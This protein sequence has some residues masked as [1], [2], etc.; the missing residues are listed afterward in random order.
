M[1]KNLLVVYHKFYTDKSSRVSNHLNI[2]RTI[3]ID[4]NLWLSFKIQGI[5]NN[6]QQDD[7]KWP[8]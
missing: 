6:R 5:V 4:G 7:S 1:E 8:R 3:I 2:L